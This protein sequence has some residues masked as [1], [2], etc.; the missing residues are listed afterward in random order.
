MDDAAQRVDLRGLKLLERCRA[1]RRDD[2]QRAL[3]R[4]LVD[5]DA[6]RAAE[7][8]TQDDLVAHRQAWLDRERA[9]MAASA[10]RTMAGRHFR[11]GLDDL[12]AM[13]DGTVRRQACL[14]AARTAVGAAETAAQV[15]RAALAATQRRLQQSEAVRARVLTLRDAASEAA[16]EQEIDDDIALRHRGAQGKR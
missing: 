2:A 3:Q 4:C 16:A 9:I 8:H 13:A 11:Q 6:A 12:E 14:G 10:G 7:R 1:L 15:A 5:I